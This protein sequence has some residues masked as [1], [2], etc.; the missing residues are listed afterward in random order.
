MANEQVMALLNFAWTEAMMEGRFQIHSLRNKRSFV[1]HNKFNC[2]VGRYW[3]SLTT[4]FNC[5][6]VYNI[7]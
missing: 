7:L 6:L 4:K 1:Q 2:V 3:Y 5:E